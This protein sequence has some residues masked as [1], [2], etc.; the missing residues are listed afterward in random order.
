MYRVA[1]PGASFF[2]NHKPRNRD[3]ELIHPMAWVGDSRNP[4]ILRQEIV[5]D[6]GSTHNH[7]ASLF[8]PEDERIYWMTKGRPILPDHSI[9]M[10]TVWRFHGPVAH[11]WH[12]APFAEELPARCMDAVGRDGI[13]ILDPFAGSCTTL[14]VAFQRGYESVGVDTSI[15]YL[16]RARLENRWMKASES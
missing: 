8:W 3:G 4:W 12:P 9:G 14:K 11:T 16:E 1:R 13:V 10:S 5:W 7:S 15:E 6:R 2:Y